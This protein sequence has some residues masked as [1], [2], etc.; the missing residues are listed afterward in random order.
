MLAPAIPVSFAIECGRVILP[1]KDPEILVCEYH[2][3][4][5]GF[6]RVLQVN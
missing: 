4:S 2:K 6:K 1:T 3:E 5:G